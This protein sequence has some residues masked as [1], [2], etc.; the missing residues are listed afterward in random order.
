M[1][2][3]WPNLSIPTIVETH[4]CIRAVFHCQR[5]DLLYVPPSMMMADQTMRACG[6]W[7]VPFIITPPWSHFACYLCHLTACGGWL[8]ALFAA[9]EQNNAP[10]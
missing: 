6:D 1:I 9:L 8:A 10:D 2:Q 3:Q 4:R 7:N 5:C